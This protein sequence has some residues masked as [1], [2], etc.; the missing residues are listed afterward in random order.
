MAENHDDEEMRRLIELHELEEEA[1]K[2]IKRK[3]E[4]FEQIERDRLL[5]ERLTY[6]ENEEQE[7]RLDRD[8]RR[9]AETQASATAPP[10][11]PLS[12]G[13]QPPRDLHNLSRQV[14]N[15]RINTP[16]VHGE[17]VN[18]EA[19]DQDHILEEIEL[20]RRR[21]ERLE[22]NMRSAPESVAKS[23]HATVGIFTGEPMIPGKTQKGAVPLEK[24]FRSLEKAASAGT[25]NEATTLNVLKLKLEGDADDFIQYSEEAQKT[26]SLETIKQLLEDRFGDP[27]PKTI[28]R[29]R[30]LECTMEEGEL[31]TQFAVRCNKAFKAT[32]ERGSESGATYEKAKLELR[33][34][35]ILG[36]KE[37]LSS[38]IKMKSPETFEEAVKLADNLDKTQTAGRS[39]R[40]PKTAEGSQAHAAKRGERGGG[41]VRLI[42]DS[43]VQDTRRREYNPYREEQQQ[44]RGPTGGRG[45]TYYQGNQQDQRLDRNIRGPQQQ[46]RN[47]NYNSQDT[48]Q[49][50]RKCFEC[51]SL[52]HIRF[53]CPR[54]RPPQAY[55]CYNCNIIGDHYN[56]NCPHPR[57]NRSYPERLRGTR[58]IVPRSIPSTGAVQV[59][60]V[61]PVQARQEVNLNELS[62]SVLN[63]T[64][65]LAGGQRT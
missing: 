37:E 2:Q 32:L 60:E 56:K 58:E 51:G 31:V 22:R 17:N 43:R 14:E 35:F 16:S 11:T 8:R 25:W 15:I 41:A 40:A 64:S 9:A 5:H 62:P 65:P 7:W 28:L 49:G 44:S 46:D 45:R 34:V 36:L 6:L 50:P 18:D 10:E 13:I 59:T 29:L 57:D 30:F 42:T 38:H 19:Y 24:F 47:I 52:Q 63:P 21:L 3:L 20:G 61:I 48:Q 55:R 33:D 23:S 26:T 4:N 1:K 27:T 12:A 39:R 54:A 53:D